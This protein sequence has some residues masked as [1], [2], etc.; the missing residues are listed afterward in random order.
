MRPGSG[1]DR[2]V[3]ASLPV[4]RGAR[5][6]PRWNRRGGSRSD[7]QLFEGTKRANRIDKDS[8]F[9]MYPHVTDGDGAIEKAC[10]KDEGVKTRGRK[11]NRIGTDRGGSYFFVRGEIL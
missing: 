8:L 10:Q 6:E 1:I 4:K 11:V 2:M 7:R 9:G 3:S 5:K